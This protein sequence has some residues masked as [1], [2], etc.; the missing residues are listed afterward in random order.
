MAL[1]RLLDEAQRRGLVPRLGD[2]RFQHFPLMIDGP[3]EVVHLA[4]DLHVDLVEMPFPVGVLAHPLDPLPA[5]LGGEH[6]T[7]PVPPQPDRLMADIDPALVQQ[8]LDV[9][10]GQRELDVHYDDQPG[11]LR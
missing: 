11:H 5:D 1:E 10:Q 4:V 3:P 8:V 6:W 2:I 7:E 9:A